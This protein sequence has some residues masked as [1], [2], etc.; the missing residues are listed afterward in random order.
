MIAVQTQPKA[1]SS[2]TC[3]L[4]QR[5][6]S[7][8]A[9]TCEVGT[10]Q[11]QHHRHGSHG[12]KKYEQ[13]ARDHRR[14]Q[15]R[16]DNPE[17]RDAV[18]GAG[19][20]RRFLEFWMNLDDAELRI[21]QAV[22]DVGDGRHHDQGDETAVKSSRMNKYFQIGKTEHD[23][24]EHQRQRGEDVDQ[25]AARNAARHAP[26]GYPGKQSHKCRR[27][28]TERQTVDDG[29]VKRRRM[30]G[31]YEIVESEALSSACRLKGW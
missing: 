27:G 30:H 12:Q 24:R 11:Q 28:R 5:S 31:P 9:T 3:P 18:A 17:E 13:P 23:R 10:D 26:A 2:P 8:T 4:F 21:A 22:R 29:V 20:T 15:Q 25:P 7:A 14:R 1:A 19:N 16:Q 6:K